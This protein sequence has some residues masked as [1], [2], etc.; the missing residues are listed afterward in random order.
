M[1]AAGQVPDVT[2]EGRAAGGGY[3][4]YAEL[5]CWWPLI[6]PPGEYASDAAA[7]SAVFGAA[8]RD[9]TTVLDL[10]SGGGHVARHLRP[11]YQ[12]TL[13]DLSAEM[14]AVSRSLNTGS[15]H[16]QGDMRTVRLARMFDAVLVHDAV[17]YI[18]TE[19]DLRQV[20]TT[21]FTHCSPGGVAV[22]VPDHTAETF[23]AGT[24]SGGDSDASGRQA[25]FREQT[26]DPDPDD[27][28]IE[29]DY[30]FTL[31]EPDGTVQVVRETH[32]LGAFRAQTW[33][34]LL[35]AA[36]FRAESRSTALAGA[37]P[38][39]RRVLFVGHRLAGA[40]GESGL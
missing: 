7:I 29:A 15:E 6:S 22:F 26:S 3:R 37:G 17:D 13:V 34:A 19:A 39:S 4:L 31:R 40:A 12:V 11:R 9:V 30:E 8:E 10:G 32:R 28:W 24:G 16:V 2:G 23:R 25:S 38:G 27:D 14:L 18:T 5:A 36:G 33:L 21:A 1:A 35:T 20:V